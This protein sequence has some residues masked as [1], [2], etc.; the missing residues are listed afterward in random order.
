MIDK[1]MQRM[2]HFGISKRDV[3]P[4]SS[5]IML[6]ARK[7]FSLKRSITDFR[8][9]NSGLQRVNVAFPLI[10]DAFCNFGKFQM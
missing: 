4:Y 5:P 8:F 3:S 7:N 1:E 2:A 6:I 9:L 10:R